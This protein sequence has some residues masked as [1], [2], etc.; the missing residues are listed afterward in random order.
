[1]RRWLTESGSNEQIGQA[2]GEALCGEHG[3][4][5]LWNTFEAIPEANLFYMNLPYGEAGAYVWI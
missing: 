3:A 2:R 1:M 4:R 5:K